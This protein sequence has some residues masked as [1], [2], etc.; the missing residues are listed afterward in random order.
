MMFKKHKPVPLAFMIMSLL[1]FFYVVSL[2]SSKMIGDELGG[3]PGG[4]VL[5]L[6]LSIFMFL[7]STYLMITDTRTSEEK[8]EKFGP[9]ERRLFALTFLMAITYV[10]AMRMI[11]F[12]LS[13]VILSFSLTFFYLRGTV[14]KRDLKVWALGSL[15]STALLLALYSLARVLTR[16]LLIGGRTGSVPPWMGT[17]GFVIGASLLLVSILYL[18]VAILGWKK[19]KTLSLGSSARDAFVSLLVSVATTELLYL[20]FRQLFLVEL[21]R[22]LV[23]W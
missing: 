23:A 4:M 17:N 10:L 2:G 12:V 13:T 7:A 21:V 6:F 15:I 1:Y 20:F 3:D 5:P 11:G 14:R 22:G 16:F 18:P 19:V 9:D 8:V